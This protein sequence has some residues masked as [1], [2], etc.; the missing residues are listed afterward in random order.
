MSSIVDRRAS[1]IPAELAGNSKVRPEHLRRRALLYVR[2]STLAQ[3][4]GNLESQRRQY[5]LQDRLVALG[6]RT[7]QIEVIDDDQGR[8]GAESR[9]RLGF[10]RLL[11]EVAL[12]RVGIIIG[13]ETSRLARNNE[14]WQHLLNLC[15]VIDTL[16]A[17]N[18]GVYSL[19]IHNDRMLLGL[20]GTLSEFEL[21]TLR[22]R[23]QAGAEN[24]ARRGE[25][26]YG[27]PVGYR[28]TED[29][30]IEMVPDESVRSALR[31]VFEEFRRLGSIRSVSMSLTDQGILLPKR[32]DHHGQKGVAWQAPKFESVKDVLKNPM[33]AGA[34]TYGRTFGQ[35]VV[36]PDGSIHKRQARRHKVGEW[37]IFIPDHHA[38]FITWDE[39]EANQRRLAENR[40]GFL[41][42]GPVGPG[43]SIL[44]GLMRCGKCGR[45]MGTSYTGVRNDC[46]RFTCR[47][48][49]PD[50]QHIPCQAFGGRL[51]EERVEQMLLSVLEPES[52]EAALIAEAE[53]EDERTRQLHRWHLEVERAAQA[54]DRSRRK[55]HEVEPG[56]RL[57][58]RAL[59]VQWEQELK[60][61]EEAKNS[62]DKRVASLAPPLTGEEK[63]ELRRAVSHLT[64]LWS[65]GAMRP[66]DRKEIVRL[67]IHH[68]EANADR[69]AGRLHFAVHWNT[70]QVSRDRVKLLSRGQHVRRIRDADLEI[71]RKM[72]ADYSDR[73]IACILARAGRTPVPGPKWTARRVK[74]IRLERRWIKARARGSTMTITEAAKA[75]DTDV[76]TLR[77]AISRG[78]LQARQAYPCAR[79]MIPRAEVR[80][81]KGQRW[82]MA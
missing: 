32:K 59:E 1:S 74:A 19:R 68:V 61:L 24:K 46:S 48:K 82:R 28:Y 29:E 3:V 51:L 49:D 39:F 67:L 55:Y 53:L 4:R 78:K 80:R 34:Y 14:D 13:L 56:N 2:Q 66:Q 8:S 81:I 11:A 45:A 37:P 12:G 73:E 75:L 50:D 79:W 10:Q 65:S 30:K 20:K 7:E 42:P 72:S 16:I 26:V 35:T 47:R 76:A 5:G 43:R 36:T 21:H 25:L 44:S 52:F 70:G 17:D 64:D 23:M 38:A 6:W 9:T 57:V 15:M 41:A 27:L 69:D 33:Y 71:I 63:R 40:R 22:E 58:A 31:R 77:G 54:E 62:Y 18:E 60:G